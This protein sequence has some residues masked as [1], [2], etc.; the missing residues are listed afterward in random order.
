MHHAE[1]R[2]EARRK[3][4]VRASTPPSGVTPGEPKTPSAPRDTVPDFED[5]DDAEW[6]ADLGSGDDDD[7]VKTTLTE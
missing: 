4:A 3:T 6:E 7:N 2:D 1:L 5:E